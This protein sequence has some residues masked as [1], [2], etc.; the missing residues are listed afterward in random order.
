MLTTSVMG[1]L[2]THNAK[3]VTG[4]S[5]RRVNGQPV[6][7][8]GDMVDCPIHGRNPIV[9][10]IPNMPL[11]DG[12]ATAHQTALAACGAMIL[13]SIFNNPSPASGVS[14]A[15]QALMENDDTLDEGVDGG[16]LSGASPAAQARSR[17]LMAA[18][19]GDQDSE[20][21]PA[22]GAPVTQ[23]TPVACRDIPENAPGS[24]R[25][26]RH[27]TLAD[28]SSGAACARG[29]GA[30]SGAVLANRGLSRAEIICNLRHLATNLLDPV[31]DKFGRSSMIITSGFRR[32]SNG[33]DHNIGSACDVQF[34][35]NG[36]KADGRKLD[37]IEKI[38]IN[39]LKLPFTQI[40]HENNSWL[41]LACRRNGVNSAKRICWWAGGAYNS[42]YRY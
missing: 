33:S 22:D 24:L 25:I 41:H 29:G 32:A 17:A 3:I 2:C 36:K 13:P 4:S 15:D 37:E 10:I 1:D 14:A 21:T 8:M 16:G 30:S 27:F 34:R 18:A 9:Q 6:A 19:G 28:L 39:T 23:A 40:I 26:S 38:I 31:A 20:P 7:R 12:R 11:T 42:G 35:F 5:T